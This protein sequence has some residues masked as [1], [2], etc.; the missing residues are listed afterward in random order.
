MLPSSRISLAR[1][2]NWPKQ[3]MFLTVDLHPSDEL[4]TARELG[5]TLCHVL[6]PHDEPTLNLGH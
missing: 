1:F 3:Q 2:P 6:L 4:Q 5:G